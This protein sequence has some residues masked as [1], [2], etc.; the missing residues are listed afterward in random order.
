MATDLLKNIRTRIEKAGEIGKFPDWYITELLGFKRRWSTDLVLDV[1]DIKTGKK[2]TETFKQVRVWHRLPDNRWIY[3][4]GERYHE[5]VTLSQMESHAMEMSFKKWIQGIPEGGSKGGIAFDPSKRTE[6]DI[7]SITIKG[8]EEAIEA[9]ILGPYI[10]R[11]APDLNTNESIMKWSQDEYAYEMRKRG[12]PQ[13]AAAFTGKPLNFG[14]MPGRKEATGLGLHYAY[15]TFRKELRGKLPKVPT[16]I[17]QGF[18][19]VGMHFAKIAQEADKKKIIV[20]VADKKNGI[21]SGVY[22]EKGLDVE[23][24]ILYAEKNKTVQGFESEQPTAAKATLSEMLFEKGADV[25]LPAALEE[26]VTA[27]LAEK[28]KIKILLEGANGPTIP[29]AD[30]ILENRGIIV[31]PDIYANAGG[32]LVSYF[33]WYQDTGI[34]PFDTELTMPQSRG[35]EVIELVYASMHSAFTRNGDR[36]MK[37]QKQTKDSSGKNISY[38]LASYLYAMER[39]FP[40]FAAK[41][42]KEAKKIA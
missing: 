12:A 11:W 27:E 8:V 22:C 21:E 25:F 28:V 20:G 36:I 16:A 31:I 1:T 15:E 10:D 14:G 23:R 38:R 18:G 34:E 13:P 32:V 7:I 30:P 40:Y 2:I 39:V 19:N 6:E 35:F 29:E 4:G 17:I 26:V 5:D 3:G 41:R 33:E 42:K 37:I 24:L 9:N